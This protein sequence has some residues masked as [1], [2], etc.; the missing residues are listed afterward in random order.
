ME[1][2]RTIGLL[3]ALGMNP[4]GLRGI[5]LY[6]AGIIA[7]LGILTGNIISLTVY[8]LQKQTGFLKL[9]EATYYMSQVPVRMTWWHVALID[10][11][12]LALCLLCMW[13]PS[14]YIRR[15]QPA[16]VLQFK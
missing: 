8:Y 15:I 9:S 13:L 6:H 2:A 10:L 11:A 5:F 7:G 3:T 12:T 1:Q 16:R 14:L 4:R